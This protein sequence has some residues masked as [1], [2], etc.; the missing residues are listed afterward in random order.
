MD[1]YYYLA[2]GAAL[3]A[4]LAAVILAR[5]VTAQAEGTERMKEIAAAIRDGANAFLW[6]EYKILAVFIAVVFAVI[7]VVAGLLGAA[8]F[9]IGAVSSILAGFFGMNIAT[10]ANVRTANAAKEHG[11]RRAL[12]I[13]FSGGAVT[14]LTV[15]GLG[16]LG[17]GMLYYLVRDPNILFDYSLGVSSIALFARVGGGI[18]TKAADVGDLFQM[19]VVAGVLA[20]VHMS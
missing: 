11:M 19:A 13:A 5:Q 14:G 18:Y 20:V 8:A 12:A 7:A 16:L 17:V 9:L 2:A 10:R 1:L 15:A 3:T 4:L 6:A